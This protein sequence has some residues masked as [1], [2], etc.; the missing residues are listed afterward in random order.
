MPLDRGNQQ[1]KLPVVQGNVTIAN[2]ACKDGSVWAVLRIT[3]FIT[4]A[5]IVQEG[6]ILY[7]ARVCTIAASKQ[8]SVRSDPR[9]MR[10]AV[11]AI[12]V[13]KELRPE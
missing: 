11:D 4:P 3:T 2:V 13:E 5:D 8:Q 9:P 10:H 1:G 7:D 12:P 6:E